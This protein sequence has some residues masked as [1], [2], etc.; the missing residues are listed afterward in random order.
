MNLETKHFDLIRR[1]SALESLV[2]YRAGWVLPNPSESFPS[3]GIFKELE[4][5]VRNRGEMT[6][7][8]N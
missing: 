3:F 4:K 7:Q 8:K 6:K 2:S 1:S 5:I